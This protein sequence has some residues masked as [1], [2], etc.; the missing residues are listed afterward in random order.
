MFDHFF[1]FYALLTGNIAMR[2]CFVEVINSQLFLAQFWEKTVVVA[3]LQILQNQYVHEE[4]S[5][6][7]KEDVVLIV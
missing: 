3:N 1:K 4:T 5:I 7:A 6:D 2:L